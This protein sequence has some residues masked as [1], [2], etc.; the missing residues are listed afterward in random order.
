MKLEDFQTKTEITW[1]PGCTNFGI[2][3]AVKEA[4]F[5]LVSQKKIKKENIVIVTGIGCHGKIFDYLNLNG[6]YTLH[7]RVI[8]TAIGIKLANQKLTVLGFGGDGDTFAEGISHFVHACNANFDITLIVHE[9]Q[10]FA[11]TTGQMTPT[12]EKGFKGPSTPFGK[13]TKPLNPIS[14]ALISGASFVAR[15]FALEKDH[16]KEILKEAI[17]HKGF[18]FVEVL[19]PCITFHNTTEFFKKNIYDLKEREH[20][21]R[22]FKKALEK[23]FEWKYSFDKNYKVPIGVFYKKEF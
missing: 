7:G 14:L 3:Q 1:C 5:E 12:T 17:F 16:L 21:F 2:L 15:S 18:S 13:K 11:L 20:N 8:P 4:L 22:N 6:F 23:S 19:Q 9:N 10:T